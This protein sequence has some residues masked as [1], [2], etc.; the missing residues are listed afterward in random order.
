MDKAG[1]AMEASTKTN[2]KLDMKWLEDYHLQG[3]PDMEYSGKK[4][5]VIGPNGCGKT[6]FLHAVMDYYEKERKF[7]NHQIVFADFPHLTYE[8]KHDASVENDS[9]ISDKGDDGALAERDDGALAEGDEDAFEDDE[10][11]IMF[12]MHN[13]HV[14]LKKFMS[15]INKEEH[16]FIEALFTHEQS[17]R[18]RHEKILWTNTLHSLKQFLKSTLDF[19]F[20]SRQSLMYVKGEAKDAEAF[21]DYIAHQASPGERNLFYISIFLASLTT[22]RKNKQIAIILDEP[23]LHLHMSKVTDFVKTIGKEL[24]NATLWIATHSVHLLPLFTF[25]ETV[26]LKDG[27]IQKRGGQSAGYYADICQSI[28]GLTQDLSDFIQ[29]IHQWESHRFFEQCLFDPPQSINTGGSDPQLRLLIDSIIERAKDGAPLKI[30]D[31]GAGKGRF[32][33]ALDKLIQNHPDCQIEYYTSDQNDEDYHQYIKENIRCHVRHYTPADDL[34]ENMFDLILLVNVLHEIPPA[35]WAKEFYRFCHLLAKDGYLVFGEALTLSKGEYLGE[36]CGYLILEEHSLKQLLGIHVNVHMQYFPDQDNPK[37]EM[38]LIRKVDLMLNFWDLKEE[39]RNNCVKEALSTLAK[40][41]LEKYSS[42]LSASE[43]TDDPTVRYKKGKKA[44]FYSAQCMNALL[45]RRS[46]ENESTDDS[47]TPSSG[48]RQEKENE[49]GDLSATIEA[50]EGATVTEMANGTTRTRYA[51]GTRVS[52]YADGT[53]LNRFADGTYVYEAKNGSTLTTM[54]DSTKI[55]VLTSGTTIIEMTDGVKF[56]TTDGVTFTQDSDG[57]T[58][59]ENADGVTIDAGKIDEMRTQIELAREQV[60]RARIIR[61][62]QRDQITKQAEQ[63]RRNDS[64]TPP[65]DVR[66]EKENKSDDL[67]ATIEAKEGAAVT[68]DANSGT[69]D[70]E[71]IDELI[72]QIE[73]ALADGK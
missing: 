2:I 56:T 18:W 49:T 46:F 63:E 33:L 41:S 6:R 71:K 61:M 12:F 38:A 45:G 58:L 22:H 31:Y 52:E 10:S 20:D 64:Q 7:E 51:N 55:F 13:S 73:L 40:V 67:N 72:A 24:E 69:L 11:G 62:E 39:E 28:I 25:E 3:V 30:L 8:H 57:S 54:A 68:E 36:N 23:E 60:K 34:P 37:I 1:F 53:A 5:I 42:L 65:F 32:G 14:S 4:N 27:V 21:L 43:K 50:K 44:A 9:D 17:L 66:Q 48:V 59:T 29:D 26:Y 19:R 15:N 70:M 35:S 47:Q 16:V